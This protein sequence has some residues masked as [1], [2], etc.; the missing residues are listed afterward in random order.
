MRPTRPSLL[1]GLGLVAGVLAWAFARSSYDRLPTLPRIGPATLLV[2]AAIELGVARTIRT[3]LSGRSGVRPLH[4]IAVARSAA[5]A[6]ASSA[7]G[8]LF[9]GGYAGF[10]AFTLPQLEK[11]LLARDAV[12]SLLGVLAGLV[13]VAAALYL[14]RTCRSRRPPAEPPLGS[15]P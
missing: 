15:A 14:E 7:A 6:R 1:L 11:S 9:A 13:L 4:P 5:L 10:G 2:L 3:R 12:T 8:A